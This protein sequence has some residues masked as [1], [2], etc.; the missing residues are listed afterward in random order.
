MKTLIEIFEHSYSNVE[1]QFSELAISTLF[2]S[3]TKDCHLMVHICLMS[4]SQLVK[5]VLSSL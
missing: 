2:L 3:I 4:I 5:Y 1:Q